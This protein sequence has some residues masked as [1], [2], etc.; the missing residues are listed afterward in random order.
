MINNDNYA[1]RK[2]TYNSNG[3]LV[4]INYFDANNNPASTFPHKISVYKKIN[5][6]WKAFDKNKE[7][8]ILKFGYDIPMDSPLSIN[9]NLI[10]ELSTKDIL[11]NFIS[12]ELIGLKYLGKILGDIYI[13]HS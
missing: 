3:K 8:V 10:V 13:G 7:T 2:N 12:A 5:N 11:S 1:R 6:E 9:Y 4:E